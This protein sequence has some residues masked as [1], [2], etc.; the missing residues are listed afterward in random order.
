MFSTQRAN[1]K[2]Q[3]KT[4][5]ITDWNRIN[6]FSFSSVFWVEKSLKHLKQVFDVSRLLIIFVI[7]FPFFY[8]PGYQQAMFKQ[9]KQWLYQVWYSNIYKNL[10]GFSWPNAYHIKTSL[11]TNLYDSI[12]QPLNICYMFSKLLEKW[13]FLK[14]AQYLYTTEI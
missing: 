7:P 8:F 10:Y 6:F 14:S 1:W 2:R 13:I 9:K 3:L 5:S 12:L 11:S 4:G